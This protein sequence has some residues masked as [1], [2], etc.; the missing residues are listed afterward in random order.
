M[1]RGVHGSGAG[2]L[3]T[4][5]PRLVGCSPSASLPGSTRSSAAF[6]L[7]C[8]AS[9]SCTMEARPAGVVLADCGGQVAAYRVDAHL[10][11]VGVLASHIGMGAGVVAD[12]D[13]AKPGC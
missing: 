6:S 12:Q 2:S 4:S 13:R 9:G 7:R 5:L 11:A 3:S 8:F 1:P 10:R